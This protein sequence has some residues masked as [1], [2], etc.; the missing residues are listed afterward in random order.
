M[1]LERYSISIRT[2]G[3]I[4]GREKRFLR[5]EVEMMLKKYSTILIEEL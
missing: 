5:L 2:S 4:S 3:M 1:I